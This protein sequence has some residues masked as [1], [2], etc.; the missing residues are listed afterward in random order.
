LIGCFG[1][2]GKARV[3]GVENQSF[4]FWFPPKVSDF[5]MLVAWKIN[6]LP[7]VGDW[8]RTEIDRRRI[9]SWRHS[10]IATDVPV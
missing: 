6:V 9:M 5:L 4:L 7:M 8:N 10:C 3:R 1:A 2:N